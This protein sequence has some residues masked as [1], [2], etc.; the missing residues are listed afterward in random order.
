MVLVSRTWQFFVH[1]GGGE[2]RIDRKACF[3]V[4][5]KKSYKMYSSSVFVKLM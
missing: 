5:F 1:G 4:G 3:Q 2:G